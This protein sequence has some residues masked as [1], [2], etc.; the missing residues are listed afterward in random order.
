MQ[1]E[2]KMLEIAS[3]P[4]ECDTEIFQS[5]LPWDLFGLL[6]IKEEK[7]LVVYLDA[8]V[9]CPSLFLDFLYL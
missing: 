9:T 7:F 4:S 6:N 5:Q 2:L 8:P 3:S 1:H